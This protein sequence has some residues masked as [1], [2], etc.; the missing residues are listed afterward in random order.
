MTAAAM[1]F[2]GC[3]GGS[4]TVDIY[5]PDPGSSV[6]RPV[7]TS[8]PDFTPD[9][10]ASVSETPSGQ[11]TEPPYDPTEPDQSVFDD[12]AFI[13]NSVF[14]G[15]YRFGV[16]THGK[17][18]T[19]VGLNVNSVYTDHTDTG[20]VPIIDEV[21]Q[22]SYGKVIIQL[23]QNELAWPNITAFI[24]KYSDLIDDIMLRQPG[25]KVFIVAL[26][27]V[28]QAYNDADQSGV[29]N[30][31]ITRMNGLLRELALRRGV[32]FIEVPAELYDV[33]GALPEEASSDGLHL[34][35]KYD[36]IWADH[37]CLSVMKAS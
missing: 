13:G 29:N 37:I 5:T 26:P 8:V 34:N 36:R 27:P 21:A 3:G 33:N 9:P 24:Q 17:F 10:V 28:T 4:Q 22:G 32:V 20:T 19:K 25:A 16:I 7:P 6:I 14:E 31:N 23:G 18:F 12:A 35:L 15:F 2:S 1:L 30:E 11:T